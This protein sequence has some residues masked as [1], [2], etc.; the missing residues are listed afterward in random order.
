VNLPSP[1]LFF[2]DRLFLFQSHYSLQMFKLFKGTWFNFSLSY[3]SRNLSVSSRFSRILSFQNI[4]WIILWILLV[5]LIWF[6]PAFLLSSLVT[7][8]SILFFK[9]SFV[10]LIL[11]TIVLVSIT[12]ISALIF[13]SFPLLLWGLAYYFSKSFTIIRLFEV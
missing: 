1:G 3:V 12:L 11:Y 6:F 2:V 7:G 10:L 8:L 4:P 5:S 9:R 13:L